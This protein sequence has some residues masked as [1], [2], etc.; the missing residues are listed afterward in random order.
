MKVIKLMDLLKEQNQDMAKNSHL[1]LNA[2]KNSQP[3][4][5]KAIERFRQLPREIREKQPLLYWLLQKG[6]PN[7]KMSKEDSHYVDVS[8]V[9]GQMCQNCKF[10][11]KRMDG[12]K[13]ICSQINEMDSP[14]KGEI[15]R[16]GWCRLWNPMENKVGN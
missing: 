3:E 9:K 8:E 7:Y 11:Y 12:G 5:K 16:L 6:T 10:I 4:I 14:S 2:E 1:Y 13:F 15:S